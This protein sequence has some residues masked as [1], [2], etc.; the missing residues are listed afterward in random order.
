MIDGAVV[1]L[2]AVLD[3]S[4]HRHTG[5]TRLF[6]DGEEQTWFYG[7]AIARYGRDSNDGDVY[8]FY[9]DEA[10]ET[11]NDSCYSTI[12]EAVGEA[13]RQ[14]GVSRADW[15]PVAWPFDQTP[16]TATISTVPVFRQ[17]HPIL[18][19]QHFEDDHSWVFSCGTTNAGEDSMLVSMSEAMNRDAT[20]AFISDLP[21]GRSAERADV[22]SPWIPRETPPFCP[23][24]E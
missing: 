19:A 6:A 9:C 24:E 8:L 3:P 4:R 5:A 20:I 7:L 1:V 15:Q 10:W 16:G 13:G 2:A 17:G 23:D 11:A 14:F 22:D 21:P 18:F 12:E